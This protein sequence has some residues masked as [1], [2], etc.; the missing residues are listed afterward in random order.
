MFSVSFNLRFFT[1]LLKSIFRTISSYNSGN[2]SIGHSVCGRSAACLHCIYDIVV[3]LQWSRH[4]YGTAEFARDCSELYGNG[5]CTHGNRL[6]FGRLFA[7]IDYWIFHKGKGKWRRYGF[8]ECLLIDAILLCVEY[9]RWME[10]GVF[11]WS[12]NVHCASSC[13]HDL[14]KYNNTEMEWAEKAENWR[15]SGGVQS[16]TINLHIDL[17]L[18]YIFIE[19]LVFFLLNKETG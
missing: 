15:E 2:I 5:D 10:F 7:T 17:D 12:S 1:E 11:N 3:W 4:E 6:H 14:W 8:D 13:V 19:M 9:H 18:N 16:G